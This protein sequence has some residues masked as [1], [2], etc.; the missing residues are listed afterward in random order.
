GLVIDALGGLPGVDSANFMGRDTP[1]VTRHDWI[2]GQIGEERAARYMCVIVLLGSTDMEIF[3]GVMEGEITL[4]PAGDGGFGYDPIFYLPEFGKT[5]AQISIEEKNKIS[6]R[7]NA[8][9]KVVEYL[10]ESFSI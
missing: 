10:N 3:H 5:A 2:L 7:A 1:Y 8:L 4:E 9:Q 6:H